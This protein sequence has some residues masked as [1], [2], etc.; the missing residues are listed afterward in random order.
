MVFWLTKAYVSGSI[1][2]SLQEMGLSRFLFITGTICQLNIIIILDLN[3]RKLC[4]KT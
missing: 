1:I 2:G 3:V 4:Y